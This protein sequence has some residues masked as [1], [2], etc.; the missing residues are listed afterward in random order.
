MEK[1]YLK[2]NPEIKDD[3]SNLYI[4]AFPEDERPPL[5]WFYQMITFKK[6]N[7]VIGYYENNEFIG[8]VYLVFYMKIVYTAFF[9]VTESKRNQGYG[10]KILNDIRDSYPE[11]TQLLCFEEVDTK[12]PDYENR[13]KRQNF[14]LRNGYIDNHLK[15][16]EGDVI[17]QSAYIGNKPISFETY[18]KIFDNTYGPGA[19]KKYL[20]EVL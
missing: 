7:Q 10:T 5:D 20:R 1:V 12:Y 17:Y 9:A 11:Y 13:L 14:Y 3:I 8:F 19:N 4:S 2:Q 15:T 16:R 18:K 6:R